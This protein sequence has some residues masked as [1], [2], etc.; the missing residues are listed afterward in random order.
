MLKKINKNYYVVL[1]VYLHRHNL[2]TRITSIGVEATALPMLAT[3]LDLKDIMEIIIVSTY[4]Y[5]TV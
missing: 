3:K 2:L 1:N 4:L 5:S